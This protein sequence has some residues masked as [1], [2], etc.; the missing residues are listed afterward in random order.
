MNQH[1]RL[2][3]RLLSIMLVIGI[4]AGCSRVETPKVTPVI[5]TLRI[6]TD[7]PAL[8]LMRALTAAYTDS[9]TTTLFNLQA[10]NAQSSVDA[11]YAGQADIA[12]VTQLPPQSAD[13]TAPWMSDLALDGVAIIVN[14]A[15][16]VDNLSLIEARELFAGVRTRWSDFGIV[17]LGDIDV[18]V[19]EDGDGTRATFDERVMEGEKL[20]LNDIILPS[21]EVA[22]NFVAFQKT[23]I[24]YVPRTRITD[25]VA[26]AVKMVGIDGQ[27]PT[28]EN[29][30]SGAYRLTRMLNLV[31][32]N[33]PGGE[34]R[35]FVVW[36][37]GKDGQAIVGQMNYVELSQV[38][39]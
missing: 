16:P 28:K 3:R 11:L 9:H 31:A 30:A 4:S 10:G 23:A 1:S 37:L 25:T 14:P 17:D 21:V 13:R 38:Q 34:L 26:P 8:P 32:V 5:T 20:G 6:V 2:G 12:G 27:K 35:Q 29:I 15:N 22:M 18:G 33:E 19:R 24:A 7:G 36:V 39:R